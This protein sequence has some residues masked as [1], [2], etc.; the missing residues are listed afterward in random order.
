MY[1]IECVQHI[2]QFLVGWPLMIYV[3]TISIFYTVVLRGIQF[4]YFFTA[5]KSAVAPSQKESQPEGN[6]TPFQAFINTINSNLGNGS[7]A[8]MGNAIFIGGPG[9]ALW[10]VIF[11]FILMAVRFAE[12]YISTVYGANATEKTALGGPMLYLKDV[13]GGAYLPYIYA[14]FCT[15]FGLVGGN[16]MQANSIAVSLTSTWGINPLWSAIALL[17]FVLYILFGGAQRIVKISVS[18]VPV[19]V[20]VFLVSTITVLLFHYKSIWAALSLIVKSGFG[21]H[22]FGAG[23]VGFSLQQVIATGMARSI[24]ATESGLGS[25]AILFGSTGNDDAIQNGFMGMVSTFISTCVS[26]IVALCIVVSGV[27]GIGLDGTALTIASFDTAFGV[28]GGWIVSFLSISFGFGVL[29]SYAYVVRSVWLF[30]TNNRFS[31]FFIILYSL[32]AF[33]GALATIELVWDLCNIS[34][35]GVLFI[36]LYG[37]VMLLPKIKTEL[38]V[39]L[40]TY[41]A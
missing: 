27:W 6:V 10:V 5:L 3:V 30:L 41:K 36:N 18:I 32:C 34:I 2:S 13:P 8:G 14:F 21:L 7:I 4:R 20:I 29:V 16:A 17:F 12:V 23:V 19:K 40:E 9:A 24:F 11:G 26:F 25:A 37:L 1:L 22:A 38:L 33:G 15:I 31:Q 39:K 35:A 28:Y